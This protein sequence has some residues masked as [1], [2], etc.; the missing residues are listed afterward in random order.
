YG[1]SGCSG[2]DQESGAG[3]GGGAGGED[4]VDEH[5]AFA[6]EFPAGTQHKSAADILRTRFAAQQGL[7]LRGLGAFEQR[8]VDRDARGA[9]EA[10]G[11]TLGLVE[12]AFA[13]LG[14]V[15]RDGNDHIARLLLEDRFCRA[16]EEIGEERLE[17]QGALVFVAVDDFEHE[18]V[19]SDGGAGGAEMELQFATVAAFEFRRDVTFI[20]Q[21]ATF[22]KGRLDEPDLLPAGHSDESL[23]GGSALL[24]AYLADFRIN[25]P[26]PGIKQAARR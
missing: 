18:F 2:I 24:S 4:V 12:L 3:V 5:N 14:R 26:E 9:A 1:N 10:R 23:G 16:D 8:L 17:P 11:E 13:I 25:E 7:S 6:V 19:G 20:G 21:T 15:Q 22:A